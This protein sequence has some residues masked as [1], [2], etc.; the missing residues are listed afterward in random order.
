MPKY[1]LIINGVVDTVSYEPVFLHAEG[2]DGSWSFTLDADGKQVVD[3]AWVEVPDDVFGGFLKQG[4][5]FIA[6]PV[7][8]PTPGPTAKADLWRRATDAE[9]V[10]MA[11][12]LASRPMRI[13]QIYSAATQITRDDELWATLYGGMVGLFGTARADALLAPSD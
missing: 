8:P 4:D 3:P 5:T 12:A 11:A 6:P 7:D 13:Q 10:Q 2:E 9:A 1:A